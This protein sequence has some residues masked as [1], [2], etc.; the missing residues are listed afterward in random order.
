M[1][2]PQIRDGAAELCRERLLDLGEPLAEPALAS[3]FIDVLVDRREIAGR[4]YLAQ[5]DRQLDGGWNHRTQKAAHLGSRFGFGRRLT[6]I[7]ATASLSE[8]IEHRGG[9]VRA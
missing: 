9:W 5:S 2:E 6:G 7:E 4:V 1:I 3:A 8:A